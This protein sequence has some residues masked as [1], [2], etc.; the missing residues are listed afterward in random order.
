MSG[1]ARTTK[2]DREIAVLM[3]AAQVFAAVTAESVAQVGP[4]ITPPQLRVLTLASTEGPLNNK[5]VASALNVHLSNASRISDRLVQ[6][7]L[8]DRR[9]SPAD[10]RNVELT[11]TNEGLR[12]LAAVMRHRQAV[13][14][15]ILQRMSPD[16][17]RA[18]VA[19]LEDFN[20]AAGSSA[21]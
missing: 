12:L 7:G 4:S 16:S 13:L 11:P 8:L 6:A 19:A 14:T 10:R 5:A 20:Q 2:A 17:R 15:D 3:Q 1:A 9:D 21:T 18:L